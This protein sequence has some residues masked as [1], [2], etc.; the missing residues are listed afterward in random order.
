MR[1][2][3]LEADPG[4]GGEAEAAADQVLRLGG[5][6]ARAGGREGDPRLADLGGNSMEILLQVLARKNGLNFVIVFHIQ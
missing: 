6:G 3:V 5:R 1:E 2:D 4:A